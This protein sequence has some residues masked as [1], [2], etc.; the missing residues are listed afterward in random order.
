ME[1]ADA[2]DSLLPALGEQVMRHVVRVARDAGR[3]RVNLAPGGIF[4]VL[5]LHAATYPPLSTGESLTAPAGRRYACDDLILTYAPSGRVL[6]Q[7]RTQAARLTAPTRA[8]VVANPRLTPGNGDGWGPGVPGYLLFAEAEA[9][10]V[11]DA[12]I[13]AGIPLDAI[14]LKQG[15]DATR[16]VV[17]DGLRSADVVHLAMHASFDSAQPL[18]SGLRVAP[19]ELL[20]MQD[21]MDQRLL[22]SASLR[23]VTLSA[24]QTGLG[25]FRRLREEAYGLYGALLSVGAAGVIASMWPVD[26]AAT[27]SLMDAFIRAYFTNGYDGGSAL[28][29]AM[30]SMR[31]APGTQQAAAA[32]RPRHL[33]P[34][35]QPSPPPGESLFS[36]PSHWAAFGYYG[37]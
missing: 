37:A 21:L 14:T 4:A 6:I 22:S 16:A 32:P 2:L 35:A 34:A 27:A 26:D 25:D 15:E 11:V 1:M 23:L 7:A 17:L 31:S 28:A 10:A 30:Q 29:L 13:D 19:G 3:R 12:M 5:P 20:S 8:C 36:H 24:C 9:R 33:A 18:A